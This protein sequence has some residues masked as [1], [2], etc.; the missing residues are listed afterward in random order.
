MGVY[1]YESKLVITK[2]KSFHFHLE[3]SKS[4][5]INLMHKIDHIMKHNGFLVQHR[6][7]NET[8]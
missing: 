5:D 6:I 1:T 3:L 2:S 4:Y 8:E 7:E